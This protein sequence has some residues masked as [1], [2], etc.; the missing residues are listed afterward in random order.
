MAPQLEREQEQAQQQQAAEATPGAVP[1]SS[2]TLG[3]PT[4]PGI[5]DAET[6]GAAIPGTAVPGAETPGVPKSRSEL[7]AVTPRVR[8]ETPALRGSISLTAGRIDDLVLIQ[9]RETI[10]SDS[11]EIVLLSPSG[12]EHPYFADFGWTGRDLTLPQGDTLWRTTGKVLTPDRPVTLTWDNGQ[13][14]R[15]ER[16]Y[17]IDE[18][19]MFTVTQRAFNDGSTTVSLAPYGLISRTGTPDILGYYILHEGPLGVFDGTLTEVDYDDLRDDGPVHIKS[20][21]GWIGITDKY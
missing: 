13:G 12:H 19:Y 1:P 15:F 18:S 9:Y 6:P 21:G 5:A 11:P 17:E 7:L 3:V 4:R 2:D 14:L 20:M 8:I 10:E 16:I